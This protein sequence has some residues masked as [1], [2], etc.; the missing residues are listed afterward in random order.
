MTATAQTAWQNRIVGHAE[1]APV[2][3]VPNPR[4]WRTH[5]PEQ[6][7]ALVGALSEFGCVTGVVVKQD[8]QKMWWTGTFGLSLH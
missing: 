6:Q 8:D 5:P 2:D 4:N 1:V 7:R 3:L